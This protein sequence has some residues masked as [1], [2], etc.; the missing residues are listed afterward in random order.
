MHRGLSTYIYIYIYIHQIITPHDMQHHMC[1]FDQLRNLSGF[2]NLHLKLC[3]NIRISTFVS[4]KRRD[5][6]SLRVKI[7]KRPKH[8]ALVVTLVLRRRGDV[9][10]LLY[11]R[12]TGRVEVRIEKRRGINRSSTL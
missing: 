9:V 11:L 12:A 1:S 7:G 5:V 4:K 2:K 3:L 8:T 10:R 6:K